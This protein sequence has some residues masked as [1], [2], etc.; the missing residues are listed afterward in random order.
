MPIPRPPQAI[1]R[2]FLRSTNIP[3]EFFAGVT[4]LSTGALSLFLN[5]KR[6]LSF[7]EEQKVLDTVKTIQSLIERI[8]PIP[9]N[10]HPRCVELFKKI[11]PN[12]E[13]RLLLVSAINLDIGTTASDDVARTAVHLD[14]LMTGNISAGLE[15]LSG[16]KIEETQDE[17]AQSE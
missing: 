16:K 5:D 14:K 2:D 15:V 9:I 7:A 6:S 12:F 11:L 1:V 13:K 8:K 3:Q 10:F 4:G 17:R